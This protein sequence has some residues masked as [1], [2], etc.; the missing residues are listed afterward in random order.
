MNFKEK[1]NTGPLDLL[2]ILKRRNITFEQWCRSTGIQSKTDFQKLKT[3]LEAA[4]EFFLP[5]EMNV[6]AQALPEPS[7]EALVEPAENPSATPEE[8]QKE[9]LRGKKRKQRV[10]KI[11][12]G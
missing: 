3:D 7:E 2:Y 12:C 10:S 5:E 9:P 4:G 6:L 11:T 8:A 1:P